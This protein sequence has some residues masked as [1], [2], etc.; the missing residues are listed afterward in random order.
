MAKNFKKIYLAG[1]CFWGVEAYFQKLRGVTNTRVGYANGRK[2]RTA[3]PLLSMTGHAETVEVSF[4]PQ[5]I[6]LEEILSHFFRIIDPTSFDRQGA[7]IGHQYRTGIYYG[8]EMTKDDLQTI[9]N[10]LKKQE[11]KYEDPIL[12]EFQEIKNWMPAEKHHQDYLKKNPN[13]YCHVDLSLAEKPL[14]LEN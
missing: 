4:D 12:V 11:E 8:P 6:S 2:K 10:F 3:Y 9:K 14:D 1:G 13:G 5:I 7:D